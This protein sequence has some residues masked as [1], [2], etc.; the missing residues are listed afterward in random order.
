MR[1]TP[2]SPQAD[3]PPEVEIAIAA[4]AA[5]RINWGRAIFFFL[6]GFLLLAEPLMLLLL[7]HKNGTI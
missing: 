2:D 7:L 3:A 5:R 4:P 1:A 6:L